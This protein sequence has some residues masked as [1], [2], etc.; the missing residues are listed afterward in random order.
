MTSKDITVTV[1]SFML[2]S[3]PTLTEATPIAYD[4]LKVL[5]RQLI[6]K[7]K[8][9]D[10]HAAHVMRCKYGHIYTQGV[11]RMIVDEAIGDEMSERIGASKKKRMARKALASA[12]P[13]LAII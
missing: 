1:N 2:T 13:Q 12:Q 3:A 11:I 8:A 9:S 6:F 4:L 10:Y 5:A 7:V